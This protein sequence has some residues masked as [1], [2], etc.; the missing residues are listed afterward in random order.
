MLAAVIVKGCL[1]LF[2]KIGWLK[3]DYLNVYLL[4]RIS[5][6]AFDLMIVAGI[7]AI[8]IDLI[9]NFIGTI[10]IL[11][12]VGAVV[13]FVYVRFVCNKVFPEYSYSQFFAFFGMLTGTASTGMMLLRAADPDLRTPA[14]ENLVYQN[15]PAIVMGF[16][17]LLL[18]TNITKNAASAN[19]A[20]II[21]GA[22][23]AYFVLLQFVIFRSYIFKKKK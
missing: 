6:F 18:A 21:L 12:A 15:F 23:L 9:T 17:M 19:T 10:L 16:P 20:L 2:K 8:Q 4:N 22:C 3:K 7:C 13:T 1:G 14:S 5:G 11:A